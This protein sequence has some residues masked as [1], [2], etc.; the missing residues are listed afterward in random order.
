M[1]LQL[2]L[3]LGKKSFPASSGCH[4][5]HESQQPVTSF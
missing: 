2:Q 1:I 4:I 5:I 3:C